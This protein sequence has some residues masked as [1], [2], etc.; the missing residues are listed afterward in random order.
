MKDL[1]PDP[2]SQSVSSRC[3]W[4]KRTD[5]I[6]MAILYHS[7]KFKTAESDIQYGTVRNTDWWQRQKERITWLATGMT[8]HGM[9]NHCAE[10]LQH[11]CKTCQK[12][13]LTTLHGNSCQPGPHLAATIDALQINRTGTITV[14]AMANVK[15]R[16]QNGR[17]HHLRELVDKCTQTNVITLQAMHRLDIKETEAPVCIVRVS[18]KNAV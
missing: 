2:L 16:S 11:H 7:V 14:L 13:H 6:K 17:I 4:Q 10:V 8:N 12:E 15:V 1:I 5:L 3:S 9:T 18:Q